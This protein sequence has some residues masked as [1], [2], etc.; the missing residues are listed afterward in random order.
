MTDRDSEK[1]LDGPPVARMIEQLDNS[2]IRWDGTLVGLTPAIVGDAARQLLASGDPAIPDLIRV[3]EDESKFAAAHVLL[4]QLSG[5]EHGAIPWN[6]L[7]VDLS[8]DGQA[9]VNPGERIDLLRRWRAWQQT[10]PRP[11]SLPE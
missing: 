8:P 3:L 1:Q 10:T 4:T 11:R 7:T 9:R 5:V 6:G 2:D